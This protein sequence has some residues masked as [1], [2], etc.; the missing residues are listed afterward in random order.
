MAERQDVE[1]TQT[2]RLIKLGM[3]LGVSAALHPFEYSKVLIQ[4]RTLLFFFVFC[5]LDGKKST[6]A[7]TNIRFVCIYFQIGFE[8]IAPRP[9]K[10][11]LGRP[12]FI[13]P[14]IFQYGL[15]KKIEYLISLE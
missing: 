1:E 8:P 11:F 12:A 6:L 3:R 13:L 10:T 4:V 7:L 9:G 5:M 14:N 15:F 2:N